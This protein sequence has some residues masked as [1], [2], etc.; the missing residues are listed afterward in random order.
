M[1]EYIF[2]VSDGKVDLGSF[3]DIEIVAIFVKAYFA[4]YYND[5]FRLTIR[6]VPKNEEKTDG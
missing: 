4:E 3:E 5:Q 6:K 2:I 1:I